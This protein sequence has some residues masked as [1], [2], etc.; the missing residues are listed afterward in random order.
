MSNQSA[1]QASVRAV[2]GTTYPYEG[3]WHALFDMAG[4]PVGTYNERLLAWIN[5]YMGESFTELNGAMAAF[6]I[7]QG[8]D[9]WNGMGTFVPAVLPDTVNYVA[10]GDSI[11]NGFGASGYPNVATPALLLSGP[12]YTLSNIATSGI[13]VNNMLADYNTRVG[14]EYD[15]GSELNLLTIMGGTNDGAVTSRVQIYRDLRRIINLARATGYERIV[16]GTLISRSNVPAQAPLGDGYFD[17]GTLLLNEDIRDYWNNDLDADQL[18]D[19]GINPI[20]DTALDADNTTYYADKVH[21][22]QAGQNILGGLAATAINAALLGQAPRTVAPATFSPFDKSQYIDLTNS[23]RTMKWNQDGFNW[24]ACRSFI[25]KST[26]KWYWEI[27][28]DDN[29]YTSVGVTNFNYWYVNFG[30]AYFTGTVNSIGAG[31]GATNGNLTYN[32]ASQTTQPFWANGDILQ[33]AM[34][35]DAQL[36]WYRIAGGNWNGSGTANPATGVG[37]VSFSGLGTGPYYPGAMIFADFG[38]ADDGQITS[39]FALSEITGIIPSGY[40][41]LD[42]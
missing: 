6:A 13:G 5:D 38:A 21:P 1:R 9:S 32:G 33:F 3:D 30:L 16:L 4:I 18:M 35:C 41:A 8:A 27:Q 15:A 10:E 34:D 28:V 40:E 26:G 19:F 29:S 22:N 14:A 12:S 37:G 42:Q 25:G 24:A 20:F 7:D 2:T 23:N 17:A 31:S 11:T 39:R 36:L